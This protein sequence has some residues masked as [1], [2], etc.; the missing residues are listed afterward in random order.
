MAP[1]DGT[2]GILW[3]SDLLILW[4][5]GVQEEQIWGSK[6][7]WDNVLSFHVAMKQI[8]GFQFM[9]QT[10]FASD[11]NIGYTRVKQYRSKW[12]NAKSYA[13]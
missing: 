11:Q 13:F 1:L 2:S 6:F 7:G 8:C 12:L 9:Q 4:R 10:L 3:I 5:K